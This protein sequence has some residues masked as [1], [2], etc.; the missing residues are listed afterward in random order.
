MRLA[1]SVCLWLAGALPPRLG[2]AQ[3]EPEAGGVGLSHTVEWGRRRAQESSSNATL[4][5]TSLSRAR[6]LTLALSLY[7]FLSM[8]RSLLPP[9]LPPSL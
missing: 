1:L 9:S 7:P 2:S 3:D 4:P 8:L 5:G 6:S